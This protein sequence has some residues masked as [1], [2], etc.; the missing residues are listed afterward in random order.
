[1]ISFTQLF[2][3]CFLLVHT[4]CRARMSAIAM[5]VMT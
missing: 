2:Y 1:M 3:L 5:H 4:T